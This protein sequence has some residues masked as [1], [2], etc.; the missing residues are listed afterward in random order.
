MVVEQQHP[1]AGP[2]KTIGLPVKLSETPAQYLRP[3]PRLGEDTRAL[4]AE[5]GYGEREIAAMLA[6]GIVMEPAVA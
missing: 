1:E 4:L 5:G 2:I 3:S 6:Q